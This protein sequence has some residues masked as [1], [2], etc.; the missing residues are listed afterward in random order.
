MKPIIT[1]KKSPLQIDSKPAKKNSFVNNT[2]SSKYDV[3]N[4][5]SKPKEIFKKTKEEVPNFTEII[6]S[7]KKANEELKALLEIQK[8]EIS[9]KDEIIVKIKNEAKKD[10]IIFI[11]KSFGCFHHEKCKHITKKVRKCI[12]KIN[13]E[14]IIDSN[15]DPCDDCVHFWN[16]ND[17][18]YLKK[19]KNYLNNK[20]QT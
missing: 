4:K 10:D 5:P 13:K 7:L 16:D 20:K 8:E 6:E 15:I 9:K 2:K 11:T 19:I 1:T 3:S 14:E 18:F 12:F 17:D